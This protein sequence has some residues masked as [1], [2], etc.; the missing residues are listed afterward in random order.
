[1]ASF[2][3]V[4]ISTVQYHDPLT[5]QQMTQA[6]VITIA[7]E[8]GA[9]GVELRADYW[10][11]KE[12]ELPAARDLVQQLGL[13][14]TYATAATLFGPDGDEQQRRRQHVDD[15]AA[16]G[17]PLLRVFQG[18]AP[19]ADDQTG[20]N[21]AREVVRYATDRSVRLVVENFAR[22]P[23]CR[24]AEIRATLDRFDSPFLGTNVDLGNYA[25]NG[26]DLVAAVRTLGPRIMYT[27]LRDHADPPSGA[28]ATYLGGGSLPLR[29]ALTEFARLPQPI[30]YCFEFPGGDDPAIRIQK[31]LAYLRTL[32]PTC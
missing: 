30:I 13:V 4:V 26:Q 29:D 23:G 3:P 16:L 28:N 7:R 32:T 1:M 19:S 6:E 9:D 15:A 10:Q 22:E 12:R 8:L 31:S 24:V 25:A 5:A 27:H 11:D 14:V 17:S 18:A 20:W 21:R 2:Q